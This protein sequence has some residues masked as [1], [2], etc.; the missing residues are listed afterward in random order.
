MGIKAT[1]SAGLILGVIL[2]FANNPSRVLPVLGFK[3][4]IRKLPLM[5]GITV[6]CAAVLGV[7]GYYGWLAAINDDFSLL[8][9]DNL[10]RPRRFMAVYG[11]HLGGYIGGLAGAVATALMIR[12]ERKTLAK[13]EDGRLLAPVV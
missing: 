6:A 5:L 1:W 3:A 4:V 13:K 10:W 12:R 9:K 8:I 7:V 2:L 11:I